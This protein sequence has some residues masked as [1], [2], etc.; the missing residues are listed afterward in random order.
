M[1][2]IGYS[3]SQYNLHTQLFFIQE[4]EEPIYMVPIEML[5]AFTRW[6]RLDAV[7][8]GNKIKLDI[9]IF[10]ENFVSKHG[11]NI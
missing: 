2:L 3:P 9:I 11:M 4:A 6:L 5:K 8:Y 10:F 1:H 7:H